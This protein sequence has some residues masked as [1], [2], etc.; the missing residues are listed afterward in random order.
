MV[1]PKRVHADPRNLSWQR[2]INCQSDA[3]KMG[4]WSW[5]S[6]WAQHNLRSSPVGGDQKGGVGGGDVKMDCQL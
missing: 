2:G 3:L 1:F 6:V 4:R 5:I